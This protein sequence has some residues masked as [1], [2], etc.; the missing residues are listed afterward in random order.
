MPI[1]FS[2]KYLVCISL[3]VLMTT[4]ALFTGSIVALW[5]VVGLEG[6]LRG[7]SQLY[8]EKRYEMLSKFYPQ[9]QRCQ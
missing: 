7:M 3:N 5:F 4:Y 6:W 2:Y 8:L 1:S 9:Y